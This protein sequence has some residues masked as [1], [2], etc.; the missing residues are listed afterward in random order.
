MCIRDRIGWVS[1]PA[2]STTPAR[3]AELAGAGLNVT[4]VNIE[5]LVADGAEG[6]DRFFIMSTGLEVVTEID[7]GLNR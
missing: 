1:P 6:D 4:F 7:G 3:Y 5:R 2:D